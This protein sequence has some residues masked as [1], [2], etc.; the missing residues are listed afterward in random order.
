MDYYAIVGMVAICLIA[1]IGFQQSQKKAT[2]EDME[3]VT[4]LNENLILCNSKLDHML[5]NDKIRDERISKHG[6][7]IDDLKSN[8]R[9]NT[10]RLSNVE[11]QI[12]RHELRL[13]HLEQ[14]VK[15]DM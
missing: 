10:E 1:L 6:G 4:R 8:Q 3:Q 14:K 13:S 2:K 9:V 15:S 5:E 7:E 12:D 11:K